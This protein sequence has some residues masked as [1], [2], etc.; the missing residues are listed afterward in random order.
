M[1]VSDISVYFIH[2]IHFLYSNSWIKIVFHSYDYYT[3]LRS[4]W[5]DSH[6]WRPV[7]NLFASCATVDLSIGA[8]SFNWV[9]VACQG[10]E[11]TRIV[12]A[13]RVARWHAVIFF[14]IGLF[15]LWL[16]G[17]F[18]MKIFFFQCRIPFV[19]IK[20]LDLHKRNSYIVRMA[21]YTC[22]NSLRPSD[23]Y[24][25]RWTNHHCFR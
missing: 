19:E 6:S 13:A 10:W 15:C 20:L 17:H 5:S 12:G 7:F 16:N 4:C 9:A 24:M 14:M 8:Q 18:Y 21:F 2:F 1:I 23:S 25:H 3:I 22:I 11:C